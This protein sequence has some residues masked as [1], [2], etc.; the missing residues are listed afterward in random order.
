MNN[1]LKQLTWKYFIQNKIKEIVWTVVILAAIIFIPYL[2]GNSIGDNRSEWC[3]MDMYYEYDCNVGMI[4]LEGFLYLIGG[5]VA[6]II[7]IVLIYRWFKSN[8][9]K[10]ERKAEEELRSSHKR[11][12]N[13]GKKE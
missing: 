4:W 5:I 12:K 1:Q 10:A 3:D 13:K 8:W 2:L 6:L 9:N 7:T 11:R